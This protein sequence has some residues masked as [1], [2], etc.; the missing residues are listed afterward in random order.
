[1]KHLFTLLAFLMV[2]YSQAQVAVVGWTFPDGSADLQA[3]TGSISNLD[4]EIQTFGGTSAI[5]FKNGF[6]NKAAQASNWE[7]GAMTKGWEIRFT[8]TGM[9][10]IHLNSRQQSGG[11]DPGPRYWRVQ[12]KVG[13]TENWT[14]VA[15]SDYELAN[16]WETGL[17]DN[18]VLPQECS[19]Q[20]LVF[21]RWIV[22]DNES[23][24]GSSVEPTGKSKIDNILVTAEGF[25]SI[26]DPADAWNVSLGP[27][28]A[29]DYLNISLP[30]GRAKFT[31]SDLMGKIIQNGEVEDHARI[32]LSGI[33]AGLYMVTLLDR[34]QKSSWKILVT[35]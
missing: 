14:D 7:G 16:D 8:T 19:D 11:N 30:G 33:D 32:S 13:E 26:A 17:I 27:N 12:Y 3:D 22:T 20:E 34:G 6:E 1:M 2:I 25:N 9:Y 29:R 5:E 35:K 15:G 24:G 10:G 28:P 4:K 21:I 31:L 18:L 23:T